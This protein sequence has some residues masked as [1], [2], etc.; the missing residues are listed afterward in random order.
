MM[1]FANLV[2]TDTIGG[3]KWF[4]NYR[5]LQITKVDIDS[6]FQVAID[7]VRKSET[8][9]S[10]NLKLTIEIPFYL[11]KNEIRAKEHN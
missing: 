9:N 1:Q 11:E 2:I 3:Q 7:V 6:L 4:A 10:G 8:Q 5:C